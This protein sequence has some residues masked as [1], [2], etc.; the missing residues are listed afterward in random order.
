[1]WRL[2]VKFYLNFKYLQYSYDDD[3]GGHKILTFLIDL[4][5][6][7]FL[8]TLWQLLSSECV[9]CCWARA[10]CTNNHP[11]FLLLCCNRTFHRTHFFS[12]FFSGTHTHLFRIYLF[13]YSRA[14]SLK[15]SLKLIWW[16]VRRVLMSVWRAVPSSVGAEKL[17]RKNSEQC[18]SDA[19]ARE[20][21]VR[22]MIF[23]SSNF[24]VY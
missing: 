22:L 2:G 15:A 5:R 24:L 23:C 1:M 11:F 13:W 3:D 16:A 20:R 8:Q 12:F 14:R 6:F 4:F 17:N 19:C 21:S 9:R 18:A 7:W 10:H